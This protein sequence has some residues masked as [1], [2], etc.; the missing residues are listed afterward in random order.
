MPLA[1][2]TAQYL[3]QA[4]ALDRED[5]VSVVFFGVIGTSQFQKRR[6]KV[7]DVPDL[8]RDRA[9]GHVPRP[10]RDARRGDAALVGPAFVAAKRRVL[11]PTPRRPDGGVKLL[12]PRDD[13]RRTTARLLGAATVVGEE[14]HQRVV[15]L[16]T[17]PQRHHESSDVLIHAVDHRRVNRHPQILVIVICQLPVVRPRVAAGEFPFRVD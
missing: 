5:V 8:F 4:F 12:R 9:L 10:P 13:L 7:D 6:Q 15:G 1:R 14:Q 2:A 16:A 3:R 11:C 17:L